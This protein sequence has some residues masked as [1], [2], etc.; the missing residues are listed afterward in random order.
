MILEF[1]A[2]NFFSFEEEVKIDFMVDKPAGPHGGYGTTAS[3]NKVSLI[4]S[5]IGPNASG[6][7]TALKAIS[8]IQ[9]LMV[10][11]F[12]SAG[13]RLPVAPFAGVSKNSTPTELA[14]TFEMDGKVHKYEV[15]LNQ[16]HIVSEK[17]S[18]RTLTS[19]R[20]TYKKLF[21]RT[22]NE[23]SNQYNID[24]SGFG[25]RESYWRNIELK[26]SSLISATSRFGHEYSVKLA[27]YWDN[28]S[29]NVQMGYH[30]YAYDMPRP[31]RYRRL[32]SDDV[33]KKEIEDDVRMYAD[34]GIDSLS[35]DDTI[36]H[37]YGDVTFELDIDD[38]SR[39]TQKFL[40]YRRMMNESLANGGFI[41]I[42]EFDAFLHPQMF[43]S[44]VKKFA[45][46]KINKGN[47]QLL[48][49]AHNILVMDQL[50]RDQI[51][52]AEKNHRGATTM[53]RL[54]ERPNVRVNDKFLTKYMNG[55]YGAW[56]KI[57][58]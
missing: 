39:G 10:S 55:M 38:E 25:L 43:I 8:V 52:F 41:V 35:D 29:S 22:I 11:S 19:K 15:V 2:K 27:K 7:T 33:S 6:K 56:P 3:G 16:R 23:D 20:N 34:L 49:T 53:Y 37:K 18:V 51:I 47:A 36:T 24:D 58:L 42:D 48:I 44:L 45:D 1:S 13:R 26:D 32:L 40:Q 5:I 17:L 30:H 14:V 46:P 54:D 31:R 9:W 28:F 57:D 4:E 21:I 12:R 50:N